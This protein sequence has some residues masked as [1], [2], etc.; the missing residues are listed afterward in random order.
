VLDALAPAGV[1]VIAIGGED[2]FAAIHEWSAKLE[3]ALNK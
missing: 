1:Q 3:A 2:L